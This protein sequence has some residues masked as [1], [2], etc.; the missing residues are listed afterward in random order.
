MGTSAPPERIARQAAA[1]GQLGSA[2][3]SSGEIH[4][5]AL[6]LAEPRPGLSWL[7]IGVGTGELLL[8]VRDRHAPASLTG[9]DLIEW[10]EDDLRGDVRMVVGPA[11]QAD[12][13]PADRVMMIE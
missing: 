4:R 7:D 9:I 6:D 3:D 11:E 13:T 10:L 1:G 2:G 8:A 5:A 12:L